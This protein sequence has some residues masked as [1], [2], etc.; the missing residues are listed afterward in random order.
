M[1]IQN[2]QSGLEARQAINEAIAQLNMQ[3]WGL[4]EVVLS[5]DTGEPFS[6]DFSGGVVVVGD[7]SGNRRAIN[8]PAY[9]KKGTIWSAGQAQGGMDAGNVQANTWYYA[10]AIY[11]PSTAAA[12]F[13]FSTSATAPTM[14]SGY[15]Y[16][17][18]IGSIQ[19]QSGGAIRPFTQFGNVVIY[20]TQVVDLNGVAIPTTATNYSLTIPPILCE[21]DGVLSAGLSADG[22]SL[23]ISVR[24]VSQGHPTLAADTIQSLFRGTVGVSYLTSTRAPFG[25]VLT[26]SHQWIT[27]TGQLSFLRAGTYFASNYQTTFQTLGFRDLAILRGL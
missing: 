10:W 24:S 3:P 6:V 25:S 18:R 5:V 2:G 17:R 9:N 14:P 13:L 27:N 19:T 21:V 20:S 23:Q 1:A 8:F 22:A 12:D 7:S 15:A 4:P 11:N 16:K 26:A